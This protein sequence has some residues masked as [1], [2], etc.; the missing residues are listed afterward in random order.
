[1]ISGWEVAANVVTAAAILLAGRNS[2][3][4]WW[5]GI[6]GCALFAWVFLESQL[7]ADVLLQGFFIVTSAIGWW[8]W[9]CGPAGKPRPVSRAGAA[10]VWWSVPI[11]VGATVLYGALLHAWTDA[12]APFVDSAVLVFS[13]IA[14]VLLMQ[15]RV[16]SWAFWLLVNTIAVPLYASRGLYL[17]SLLY[18]VYWVN[19]AV[20]IRH[21]LRLARDA[22][23]P[24]GAASAST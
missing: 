11:G 15:R 24:T 6:V 19:A 20:S 10:V 2:V 8:Q 12:Y 21:W 5:S 9:Q 17:T 13:V 22:A 7:Y 23:L 1:M 4:T 14:Q 16:E 18:V 3:H